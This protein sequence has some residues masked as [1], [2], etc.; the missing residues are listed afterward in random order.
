MHQPFYNL[1]YTLSCKSSHYQ[2]S[3][4]HLFSNARCLNF[5]M[6]LKYCTVK[7]DIGVC[8][9]AVLDNYSCGISVILI[10]NCGIAVFS[11]DLRD[12]VFWH[13]GRYKNLSFNSYKVFRA[14][15]SFRSFHFLLIIVSF[16]TPPVISYVFT[17]FF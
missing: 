11:T 13:F 9:I 4:F 17:R 14:I 8:D 3:N 12:A 5:N 15:S 16:E 1:D 10:L 7:R 2:F 6:N